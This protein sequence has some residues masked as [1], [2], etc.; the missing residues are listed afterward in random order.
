MKLKQSQ[1]DD[2]MICHYKGYTVART[3]DIVWLSLYYV[4]NPIK[5]NGGTI[6]RGRAVSD[7][8]TANKEQIKALWESGLH[9]VDMIAHKLNI[10]RYNVRYT[11]NAYCNIK[12]RPPKA[13]L[14]EEI[15]KAALTR[16]EGKAIWGDI[17][18]IAR[19]H[20]I[21]RQAVFERLQAELQAT[22]EQ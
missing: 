11:L 16:R 2:I 18:E 20:H 4:V 14:C 7:D 17:S 12:T 21:S 9:N 22:S 5:A 19:R 15:K 3:A 6:R 10:S 1:I 13:E 8:G